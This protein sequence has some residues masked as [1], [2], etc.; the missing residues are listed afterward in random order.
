[1]NCC[2]W[3]QYTYYDGEKTCKDVTCDCHKE[4]HKDLIDALKTA[5]PN[6]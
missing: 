6:Y 2:R 3:C 4:A 5:E 1:M